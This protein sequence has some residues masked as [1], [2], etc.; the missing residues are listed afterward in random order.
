MEPGG[1]KPDFW[2]LDRK[3]RLLAVEDDN[4]IGNLLKLCFTE[5]GMDV[6]VTV[7][8]REGVA[9]FSTQLFDLVML[10]VNLPDIDGFEV[11]RLIKTSGDRN[12]PVYFLTQKDE[13]AA[14]LEGLG[15]GADDYITKPFDIEELKLRVNR[16]LRHRQNY[17]KV[18]ERDQPGEPVAGHVFISYSHKDSDF[19]HRLAEEIERHHIPVWIDD[20]IDYGTRWPHVIQEKIDSCKAFILIMSDNARASDWVNNELTYALGKRRKI[21]PLLLKGETWLSV[22]TIQYVNVRNRKLPD[23]SFYKALLEALT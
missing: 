19:T 22:A 17:L 5:L 15:L 7:L 16:G 1:L 3:P 23:E 9:L 14:K 8:G 10:D 11:M 12:V 13:R 18:A 2:E 4:D 6:T 20:R 21:F